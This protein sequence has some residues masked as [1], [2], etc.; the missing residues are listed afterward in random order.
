MSNSLTPKKSKAYSN[1][2]KQKSVR[3]IQQDTL[4]TLK[5][6]LLPSAGCFGS[7]TQILKGNENNKQFTEYS[8]DGHTILSHIKFNRALED[9]IQRELTEMTR[10]IVKEVGDGTTSAV[11]LSSLIYDEFVDNIN[12]EEYPAYRVIEAFQNIVEKIKREI[13]NLGREMKLTDVYDIAMICT[14]NNKKVSSILS[15][16]YKEHG[17]NVFIDVGVSTTDYD[18]IKTYDGLTLEVGYSDPVY[19]NTMPKT[20]KDEKAGCCIIKRPKIYAFIDNIDTAEMANFFNKIIYNNI[21]EPMNMFMRTNNTDYLKSLVPTVIMCP[22]ITVDMNESF[23]ALVEFMYKFNNNLDMKPPLLVVTNISKENYSIYSDIWRLAGCKTIQKYI[24]P[25]IQEQDI[26]DGKAPNMDTILDFCGSADMVKSD[27]YKTT[28]INPEGMFAK[29]DNGEYK[30]DEEGNRVYSEN[31][32]SQIAFLEQELKVAIQDNKTY[33]IIGNLRRRLHSLKANM[34]DYLVGGATVTDRD[35]VRAL[36]EDAVKNIRSAAIKGVGYG[37]NYE[38]MFISGSMYASDKKLKEDG[39]NMLYASDDLELL[40]LNIISRAYNKLTTM[41][42][43]TI[44]FSKEEMNNKNKEDF[45]LDLI[46]RSILENCP[47]NFVTKK[48]DK[49]VLCTIDQDIVILDV[50]AKIITIMF[51][52]NQALTQSPAYNMYIEEEDM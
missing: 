36:V 47:M 46:N 7:T 24:D 27:A 49:T 1:I 40:M 48:F 42:Y 28:I 23:G 37:T 41:L 26:K 20:N 25:K 19:I 10:Y 2:V 15:D 16:I 13:K 44:Y 14:N 5:E 43:N 8:K 51:T 33:D 32:K 3:E 17:T 12:L 18:I 39:I 22:K 34:V 35:S 45:I 6:A 50:I 31:Y 11:I 4:R 29:D 30:F 9:S 52:T 21:M 38:G